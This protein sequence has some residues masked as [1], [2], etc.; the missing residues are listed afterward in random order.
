MSMGFDGAK[1]INIATGGS[2]PMMTAL[3]AG[4]NNR[5][6]DSFGGSNALLILFLL[7]TQCRNG[8]W[9][10]NTNGNAATVGQTD[11]LALLNGINLTRQDSI[12]ATESASQ[13]GIANNN[14]QFANL[15]N[16]LGNLSERQFNSALA[17]KDSTAGII[18]TVNC[19]SNATQASMTNGFNG[20]QQAMTNYAFNLSSMMKDGF[21]GL[22][23]EN[24]QLSEKISALACQQGVNTEK[25]LNAIQ[26]SNCDL[27]NKIVIS[28]KDEMIRNLCTETANLRAQVTQLIC[29]QRG[30]GNGNGNS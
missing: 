15:A 3:I 11:F 6:S 24:C 22:S 27:T 5:N 1:E 28:E 23:K 29:S 26:A 2:D 20:L 16:A 9:G 25:I 14:L 10:G 8:V 30:N 4:M 18:S 17:D 12:A 7:F 19:T 21:F 13:R